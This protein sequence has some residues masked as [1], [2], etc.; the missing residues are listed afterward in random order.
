ML[1]KTRCNTHI[2]EH[3]YTHIYTYILIFNLA[4]SY[5][6]AVQIY[7][8]QLLNQADKE[9]STTINSCFLKQL[10]EIFLAN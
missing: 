9:D 5:F 10:E 2:Y 7:S 6:I 1:K 4:E 8:E 3:I